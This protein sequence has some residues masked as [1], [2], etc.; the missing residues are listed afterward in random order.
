MIEL[1]FKIPPLKF[2]RRFGLPPL[3][4]INLTVSLTGR[5]N[6][7]CKTCN[8][9]KKEIDELSLENYE[10]IFRSIGTAPY[11]IT[12]SGGEPFLR[13]DIADICISACKY[14][15]PLIINI[16]TNGILTDRI[17][18]SVRSILD[19]CPDTDLIVNL[20]IDGIGEKHDEIRG[21]KGCYKKAMET[22]SRLRALN[23]TNFTLGVHTVISTYNMQEI[24]A[25]YNQ[26]K[27][28]HPDSYITE[29]AEERVELDTLGAGITP[30]FE[31][32]SAAIDFIDKE[33][34]TWNIKRISKITRA[35]R[36][37]YYQTV[38]KIL[39]D[40]REVIPCYAAVASCQIAPNGD[41]WGCCIKAESMGNLVR[42]DYDFRKIWTS[43]K[44]KELRQAIKNRKCFCPLANASYTNMLFSEKSMLSV[45]RELLSN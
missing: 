18:N 22:Y 3:L 20:S 5:C 8:I 16:P 23:Y 14:C 27:L 17:E 11:W 6:S 2:C 33:M 42:A 12:F 21:T 25:L 31:A 45:T 19:H 38:K 7:R 15:K 24:P 43:E 40:G 41:V 9:Y 1:L 30:S 26:I 34:K 29:I 36:T 37:R 10:K 4:P 28:L 39:E 44:A 32:Y 13:K 35:F